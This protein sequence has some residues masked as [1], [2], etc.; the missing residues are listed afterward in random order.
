MH[1]FENKINTSD[2]L[3]DVEENLK[4]QKTW[5]PFVVYKLNAKNIIVC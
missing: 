1:L 5:F 3:M 2:L 4:K